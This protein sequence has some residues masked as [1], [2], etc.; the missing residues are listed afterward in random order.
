MKQNHHI[1]R[2][3]ELFTAEILSKKGREMGEKENVIRTKE[4][5]EVVSEQ[6]RKGQRSFIHPNSVA[7]MTAL[8]ACATS[9]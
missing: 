4:E 7:G 8:P 2:S 5:E 6:V 1:G 9:V 3:C